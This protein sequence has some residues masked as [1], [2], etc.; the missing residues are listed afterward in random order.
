[1]KSASYWTIEKNLQNDSIRLLL[2]VNLK[3]LEKVEEKRRDH[4]NILSI[5]YG[6]SQK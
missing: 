5:M 1:M 4:T 3:L 6:H 2:L